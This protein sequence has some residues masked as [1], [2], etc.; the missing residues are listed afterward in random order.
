VAVLL[1]GAVL[2]VAC[3]VAYHPALFYQDSWEYLRLGLNPGFIGTD[4]DHPSGYPVL[5]RLFTL[6]NSSLML[7]TVAQHVAGLVTAVMVYAIGM[8]VRLG[9]WVS[10]AI[11]ALVAL[12]AD[13]VALEQFIMTEPFFSF[14][15]VAAALLVI[16]KR[17]SPSRWALSGA[18]IGAATDMR[19]SGVFLIPAWIAFMLLRRIG[20]RGVLVGAAALLAPIVA[21]SAAHAADGRGF[22][23]SQGTGF[24]LYARVAP[25]ARCT[26]DWPASPQ[27]RAL[28]PTATEQADHWRPGQYLWNLTS[29]VN[30]DLGGIF[31][32][33]VDHS[34]QLLE[35]FARQAL[36]RR[37]AAYLE[38]VGRD[39]LSAFDP[40]GGG[41]EASV[42]FPAPGDPGPTD[43]AVRQR[44]EPG[45]RRE[46]RAPESEL[47]DYWTVVHTPRPLIGVLTAAGLLSLALAI[48]SRRWRV[49]AMPSETLLLTGMGFSLMVGTIATSTF[50]MRYILPSVPF[51]ALGGALALVPAARYLAQLLG[52]RDPAHR[53]AGGR[54]GA[55]EGGQ[56][57][58]TGLE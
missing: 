10:A 8:K 51:L 5:V 46:S 31:N 36:L 29:P 16:D 33:N 21:Y 38:M 42:R 53:F 13:W 48:G 32:R 30:Q 2:R 45:Y 15:I 56:T 37:P 23:L 4:P 26:A 6:D 28:C 11:A 12:G 7:L 3:E 18:L 9:R 50:N 47:R 40:G 14:C 55:H 57:S 41:W 19:T 58:A 39:V 27:L 44:D 25:I 22:G 17:G 35:T 1:G 24:F 49:H 43:L 34:N 54:A 52:S 20:W